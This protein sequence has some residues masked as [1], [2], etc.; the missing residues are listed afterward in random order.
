MPNASA[1]KDFSTKFNPKEINVIAKTGI[2]DTLAGIIKTQ[3]TNKFQYALHVGTLKTFIADTW[4]SLPSLKTK[5][6]GILL[7]KSSNY[8]LSNR[9]L[10]CPSVLAESEHTQLD[11][12]FIYGAKALNPQQ[13]TRLS[14]CFVLGNSAIRGM[15]WMSENQ[16]G[17]RHYKRLLVLKRQ[18]FPQD[19]AMVQ[20]EAVLEGLNKYAQAMDD[21]RYQSL[22]K[23]LQ[24]KRQDL[25]ARYGNIVKNLMAEYYQDVVEGLVEDTGRYAQLNRN[26]LVAAAYQIDI[27]ID[28]L[29]YRKS[30]W[31]V[32][33][34]N[35]IIFGNNALSDIKGG[36]IRRSIIAGN[37]VG[38]DAHVEIS[39]SFVI[40]ENRVEKIGKAQFGRPEVFGQLKEFYGNRVS[41]LDRYAHRR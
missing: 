20:P 24:Q 11:G 40:D 12:C 29:A 16:I 8:S 7:H 17:I 30:P 39:D 6:E 32:D 19:P 33:I 35:S 31:E 25:M 37:P 27:I 5:Q 41:F 28:P 18:L 38:R 34:V 3:R 10:L 36:R 13:Y 4:G 2:V 9:R 23:H 26:K 15:P 1:Q 14:N 21:L 22:L